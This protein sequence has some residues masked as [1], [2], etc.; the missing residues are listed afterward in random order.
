MTQDNTKYTPEKISD[1]IALAC[2]IAMYCYERFRKR[3]TTK[4]EQVTFYQEF[5]KGM[6]NW[7]LSPV[8]LEKKLDAF[9]DVP[10]CGDTVLSIKGMWVAHAD[11]TAGD[12]YGWV[13]CLNDIEEYKTYAKN[14]GVFTYPYYEASMGDKQSAA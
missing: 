10:C 1:N 7:V 4:D 14:K 13:V 12:P 6:F 3:K 5:K 9:F 8:P 11:Q 2:G